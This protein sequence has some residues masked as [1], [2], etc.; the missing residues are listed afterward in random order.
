MEGL[1][2]HARPDTAGALVD[3]WRSLH[4]DIDVIDK[5]NL[6][7]PTCFR[8]TGAQKNTQAAM[9]LDKFSAVVAEAVAEGYPNICLINWTRRSY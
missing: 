7:C 8:G 6:Q 4:F 2:E 5:C 9:P 1:H 3:E